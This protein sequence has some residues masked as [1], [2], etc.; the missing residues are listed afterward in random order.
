MQHDRFRHSRIHQRRE[1]TEHGENILLPIFHHQ[2]HAT[3]HPHRRR[4]RKQRRHDQPL[5]HLKTGPPHSKPRESQQ[6]PQQKI[7]PLPKQSTKDRRSRYENIRRMGNERYVRHLRMERITSRRNRHPTSIRRSQQ[8]F[9]FPNGRNSPIDHRTT[10]EKTETKHSPGNNRQ[11]RNNVPTVVESKR[12]PQ[13]THRGTKTASLTN[14]KQEPDP[15]N[16]QHRRPS[17]G[18]KASAIKSNRRDTR[19]VSVENKRTVPRPQQTIRR[20]LPPPEN[21]GNSNHDKDQRISP[22]QR[23]SIQDDKDPVHPHHPQTNRHPRHPPRQHAQH[24]STQ[25]TGTTVRLSRLRKI[26]T[27]RQELTARFRQDP[28]PLERRGPTLRRFIRRRRSTTGSNTDTPRSHRRNAISRAKTDQPR[29]NKT[30]E[31]QRSRRKHNQC[32]T[33]TNHHARN[34]TKET[35]TQ[36]NVRKNNKVKRQTLRRRNPRRNTPEQNTVHSQRRP[37]RNKRDSSDLGRQ[38]PLQMAHTKQPQH[39]APQHR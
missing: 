8:T 15:T 4:Q 1:L 30:S 19:E 26:C 10:T 17:D 21:T 16:I 36:A 31:I 20:F 24:P 38:I 29:P 37:R 35:P 13:T 2:R 18:P 32:K 5:Q 7:P 39:P 12:T 9:Q 27:S 14:E 28:R 22:N 3:A 6:H 33:I 25:P 11:D 34:I 23:T